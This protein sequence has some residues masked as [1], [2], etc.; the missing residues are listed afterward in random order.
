[1]VSMYFG[2]KEGLIISKIRKIYMARLVGR[3]AVLLAAFGLC[4]LA[5]GQFTVLQGMEFFDRVSLLHVLWVIWMIDMVCQLIP[6]KQNLALGSKKLFARYFLPSKGKIDLKALKQYIVETTRSAYRILILWCLLIAALGVLHNK[7][8]LND[9]GLF[10]VSVLF[11]VCDLI[12]V[13]IW[14]PF[15]LLL[16]NRCCTTCRIFNWD[17]VMMFTPMIFVNGFYSISLLV[18]SVAV[19]AVWELSVLL[20]P[21]R[22]WANSNE[23]LQCANCTDKLCTQ[24]CQKL[25]PRSKASDANHGVDRK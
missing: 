14:C 13:L 2:W 1:M 18:V 9:T 22:F 16:K 4:F 10:M 19:W 15:R 6:A 5:P 8:I 23:T 20:H 3:C 21:E 25:R 12:C 11:Y 7:G 24:Y 17:H